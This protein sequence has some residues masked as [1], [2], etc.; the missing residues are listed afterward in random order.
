MSFLSGI[1]SLFSGG[2]DL[3]TD[4]FD[5]VSDFSDDILGTDLFSGASDILT[6]A[7]SIYGFSE[8][9]SAAKNA[10]SL[11]ERNA[12]ITKQNIEYDLYVQ[13]LRAD[14]LKSSQRAS[15]AASGVRAG[16]GSP[17]LVMADTIMRSEIDSR[18]IKQGGQA[19][20]TADLFKGKA[21]ADV[22]RSNA[23]ESLI[24][25][26]RSFLEIR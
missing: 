1:G 14:R 24:G 3:V 26:A 15:F 20:V 5:T 21:T 12:D 19:Q 4:A 25:G 16:A 13:Q 17:L 9:K 22:L 6:I 11:A 23:V 8:Q 2:V 7:G 10:E 18:R